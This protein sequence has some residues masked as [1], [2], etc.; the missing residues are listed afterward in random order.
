M[1]ITGIFDFFASDYLCTDLIIVPANTE[2]HTLHGV[3]YDYRQSRSRQMLASI[4][5]TDCLILPD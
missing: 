1:L 3:F 4:T 2:K 5:G